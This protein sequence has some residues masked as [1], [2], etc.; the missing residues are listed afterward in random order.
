VKTISIRDV[1]NKDHCCKM[2][3]EGFEMPIIE[4]LNCR[5]KKLVFE[6]SFDIDNNIERYRNASKKMEKQYEIVHWGKIKE[7][8]TKWKKEWFPPCKTIFCY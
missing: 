5:F 8:H 3:I 6:W 7:E 1:I 4:S 2:D